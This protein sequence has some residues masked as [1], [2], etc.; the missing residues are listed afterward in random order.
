MCIRDRLIGAAG[1]RSE[2]GKTDKIRPRQGLIVRHPEILINDTRL[3]LWGGEAGEYQEAKGLPHSVATA[4]ATVAGSNHGGQGVGGVNQEQPRHRSSLRL[5][6][7]CH[8]FFCARN[9]CQ[10]P[11]QAPLLFRHWKNNCR[12]SYHAGAR[13]KASARTSCH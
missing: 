3:P 7:A 11:I 8:S 4:P 9:E 6:S 13:P 12:P 5:A 2:G 1:L 10:R